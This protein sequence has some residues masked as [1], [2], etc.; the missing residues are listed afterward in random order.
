MA[1]L[2]NLRKQ[3]ALARQTDG[4]KALTPAVSF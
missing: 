1:N 3:A 4:V 2:E